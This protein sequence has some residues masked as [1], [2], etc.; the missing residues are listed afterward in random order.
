[1]E[2][3]EYCCGTV[4]ALGLILVVL[5]DLIAHKVAELFDKEGL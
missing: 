2:V 1:M 4:A 5:L 3:W